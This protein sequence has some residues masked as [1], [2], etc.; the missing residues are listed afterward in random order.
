M[1]TVIDNRQPATV[2]N[3]STGLGFLIGILLVIILAVLF[4]VYGLPALRNNN[5]NAT[6]N[7]NGAGINIQLPGDT[8]TGNTGTGNTGNQTPSPQY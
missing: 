7:N 3:D 4:F 5:S 8:G 6:P 1:P 2:E